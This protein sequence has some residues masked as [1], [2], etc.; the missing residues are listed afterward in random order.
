MLLQYVILHC[1]YILLV[2]S[3]ELSRNNICETIFLIILKV[4]MSIKLFLGG[5]RKLANIWFPIIM[6]QNIFPFL[7]QVPVAVNLLM[8]MDT[9]LHHP[10]QTTTQQMQTAHTSS[11][12][13]LA[14][15]SC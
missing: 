12:S 7:G 11:P 9:C 5:L 6:M 1:R 8:Q 3:D 2:L 14:L 4:S 13:P 10:T 15:S